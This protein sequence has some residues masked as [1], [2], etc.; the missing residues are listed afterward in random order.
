M[1]RTKTLA[2][3][4]AA[5]TT[6]ALT[7]ASPALAWTGGSI[8]ASLSQDLVI[9]SSIG[10][11]TCTTSSLGGSITSAG[12]L[13]I[14]SAS[15]TNCTGDYPITVTTQNLSWGGSLSGGV[16]TITGFRVSAVITVPLFGNITCIYGGDLSGT[17]TGTS[18][19][20]ASFNT[21]VN[22]VNSGSHWFCPSTAD[23]SGQY[24]ITGAGL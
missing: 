24:T 4:T 15:I 8:S 12:A 13:T 19:V 1:S 23:V 17:Y 7:L 5:A 11:G 18:P 22:K 6:A 14:S 20:V 9:D 21:S 16:A 10:G 2:L 3:A